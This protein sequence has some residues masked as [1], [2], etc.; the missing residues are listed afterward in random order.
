VSLQASSTIPGTDVRNEVANLG[1]FVFLERAK[2]VGKAIGTAWDIGSTGDINALRNPNV[3]DQMLNALAPRAIFRA[4]SSLE[5]DYI[6]SMGTG[7][8]QVRGLGPSTQIMH[9]L[10][11][12]QLEVER[13]QVAARE[14]YE[15]QTRERAVVQ[16]LGIIY[17]DAMMSGDSGEMQNVIDRAVMASVPLSSVLKSAQTRMKREQE[18]DLFD[19][20][21]ADK[22]MRY[23]EA[24]GVQR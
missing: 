9:A 16:N 10:G 17:A 21:D 8:P 4:V 13:Q 18:G 24:L 11:L 22:V 20:F 19:R 5:G 12:N 15:D 2:A 7:Y 23:T 1:N 14:L 6:K 3:R